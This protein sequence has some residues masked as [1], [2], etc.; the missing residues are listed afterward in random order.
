[1]DGRRWP[2]AGPPGAVLRIIVDELREASHTS[3]PLTYFLCTSTHV[4]EYINI[5]IYMLM[6]Y[7]S[8]HRLD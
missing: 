6:S 1:M 4:F 7:V 3:R 5:L 8:Y 2:A